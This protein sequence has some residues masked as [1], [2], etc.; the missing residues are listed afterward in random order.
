MCDLITWK[1]KVLDIRFKPNPI[2]GIVFDQFT[3]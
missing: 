1:V 3:I 2:N